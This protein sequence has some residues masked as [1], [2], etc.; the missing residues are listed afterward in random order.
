MSSTPNVSVYLER[1]FSLQ[2][3][4]EI[5]G[6]CYLPDNLWKHMQCECKFNAV[7]ERH[8]CCP[9][10]ICCCSKNQF[11]V[12]WQTV[13][14]SFCLWYSTFLYRWWFFNVV[15]Y[16]YFLDWCRTSYT[17]ISLGFPRMARW[18]MWKALSRVFRYTT[19]I[20]FTN[21]GMRWRLLEKA[22]RHNFPMTH[23]LSLNL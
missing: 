9:E 13:E 17:K 1:Y 5:G 11:T 6:C 10:E 18:V 12:A 14:V 8:Q 16:I 15:Q 23:R 21:E 19:M 3:A 20:G 2:S 4:M 22:T 7:E